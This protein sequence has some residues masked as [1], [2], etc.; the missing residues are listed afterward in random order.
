M[1]TIIGKIM[2]NS[3][4]A[5][6]LRSFNSLRTLSDVFCIGDTIIVSRLYMESGGRGK[7]PLAAAEI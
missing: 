5:R 6:P 4:A 2:A 3:T 1:T 7:Q